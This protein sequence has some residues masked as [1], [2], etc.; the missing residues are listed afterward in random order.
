MLREVLPGGAV[1]NGPAYPV[2]T[3]VGCSPWSRGHDES[4]C[5]GVNAFFLECWISSDPF[6]LHSVSEFLDMKKVRHPFSI[7]QMNCAGQNL[8]TLELLLI[9]ARTLWATDFRL[10]SGYHNGEGGLGL[11]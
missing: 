6:H 2:G 11:G 7:G 5:A 8:A 10:A 4:V 9:N 3:K 1:I